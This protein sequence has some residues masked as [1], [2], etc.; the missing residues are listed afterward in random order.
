MPD[1]YDEY[2]KK[3]AEAQRQADRTK[4]DADRVPWLRLVEGWLSLLPTR[5]RTAQEKFDDAN[6][7]L[8]TQQDAPKTSQ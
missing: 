7:S 4:N 2:R 1:D 8:G 3:G 5:R 6:K